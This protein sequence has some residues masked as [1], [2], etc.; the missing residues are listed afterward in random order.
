MDDGARVDTGVFQ[1]GFSKQQTRQQYINAESNHNLQ[2]HAR[3]AH[4]VS[5]DFHMHTYDARLP[6]TLIGHLHQQHLSPTPMSNPNSNIDKRLKDTDIDA[7]RHEVQSHALINQSKNKT[8]K[9]NDSTV[10]HHRYAKEAPSLSTFASSQKSCQMNATVPSKRPRALSESDSQ[11]ITAA[12][13][14][15]QAQP[16][17][18][19][20]DD[21]HDCN[22]DHE[23]SLDEG[24]RRPQLNHFPTQGLIKKNR[25]MDIDI[26]QP[27]MDADKRMAHSDTCA[28]AGLSLPRSKSIGLHEL[29]KLE[30]PVIS[31]K[32]ILPSSILV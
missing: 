2:A 30:R 24:G 21:D 14:Y 12:S 3:A 32:S 26:V 15:P 25:K 29:G 7:R 13:Y 19:Q 1:H 23:K 28:G 27:S 4:A 11:L 22:H 6:A 10:T 8:S 5:P 16:Q 17:H 9:N 18:P 20:S 31:K